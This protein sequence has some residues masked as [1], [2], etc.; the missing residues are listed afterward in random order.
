MSGW[1]LVAAFEAETVDLIDSAR[2]RRLRRNAE[3]AGNDARALLPYL[4]H[5]GWPGGLS[6]MRPTE[7]PVL[8]IVAADDQY[9]RETGALRTWLDH[10]T[11]IEVAGRN[12]HDVLDDERVKRSVVAFLRKAEP[13]RS[14]DTR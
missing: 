2:V 14:A 5:G 4:R 12:H 6:E 11:V 10:A 7:I 1:D 9:M 13:T 8:L 3:L